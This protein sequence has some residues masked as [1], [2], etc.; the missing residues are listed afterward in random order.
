MPKKATMG[1]F[2]S[3]SAYAP[4]EDWSLNPVWP[5][6]SVQSLSWTPTATNDLVLYKSTGANDGFWG[7]EYRFPIYYPT[8][9]LPFFLPIYLLSPVSNSNIEIEKM[10]NLPFV[11][12]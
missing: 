11:Q 5:L 10:T 12:F 6:G 2:I 1:H 9:F 3:P 8:P 7:K 4:P